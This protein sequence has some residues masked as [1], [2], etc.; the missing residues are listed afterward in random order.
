MKIPIRFSAFIAAC[1]IVIVSFFLTEG[2]G[3]S[4]VTDQDEVQAYTL[5][6]PFPMPN[7]QATRFP[8]RI[9]SITNFGAVG[10]GHTLNTDAFARAFQAC[11]QAG[12]GR[13]LVPAG[14]WLTGPVQLKSNIDLHLERGALILFSPRCE[15]YP[16]VRTTYEGTRSVRAMSPIHG[17][18]LENI[19]ITGEGIIDGSGDAWRPVKK[20]KMTDAQWK[21]LVASGGA[22]DRQGN[23]WYPSVEAMNGPEF[24]KKLEQGGSPIA[25]EKYAGARQYLRPVMVS[26]IECKKVLLDGPTFQNSPAWNIHPLMCEDLVIRNITVLNPWYSQNGDGL[27]LESCRGVVVYKCSFDVGDDAICIKSGKDEAGRKR[28]R[29]CEDI[30]IADCVVYHGHGGFTVGSEMSGGVRNISVR[31]CI[32]LGTDV[33]LRFKTTR[34]R[35]G[36]VE[37][38]YISDIRMKDIPTDAI[39]FNM[40]YGGEAPIPD[41]DSKSVLV[42]RAP[43]PVD[44]KTPRFQ[45]IF[46]R[47]IIC[48]G[49]ERAVLLEGLPEMAIR[50]I[51][52]ENVLISSRK[53][54]ECIDADQ[55]RLKNAR[56]LPRTGPVL[57]LKDS[58]NVTMEKVSGP[59][60]AELFVKLEGERTGGIRILE[61][62]LSKAKKGIELGKNVPADA[63]IKP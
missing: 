21:K 35:G 34:G 12:G 37:K 18:N 8:D 63:V 9:V 55:I 52:L 16:M 31:R 61:T 45:S 36:V 24:I 54:L 6:L 30:V 43:A 41:S 46:L 47:N 2:A 10:D 59:E 42:S 44:E 51:E 23:T 1:I 20:S 4:A 50:D 49:A 58:R 60:G 57:S 15:D 28:G 17:V 5:N 33:G 40:Y 53:G 19:A 29:P 48:T 22:V 32:F 25:L 62:D 3:S 14:I 56:I 13:V 7:V 27:D 39:G 38:I 11:A 26:L